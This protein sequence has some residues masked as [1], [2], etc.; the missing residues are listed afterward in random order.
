MTKSVCVAFGERGRGKNVYDRW[1]SE[2]GIRANEEQ[3]SEIMVRQEKE[4]VFKS[5]MVKTTLCWLFNVRPEHHLAFVMTRQ[6]F[7]YVSQ[8]WRTK[9]VQKIDH[10]K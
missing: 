1:R 6:S 3:Q 8:G 2:Y 7:L 10:S 5:G 4:E 9:G